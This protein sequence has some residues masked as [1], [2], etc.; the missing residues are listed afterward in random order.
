MS[1]PFKDLDNL[2]S[3]HDHEEKMWSE[4]FA[5]IESKPLWK[6][7]LVVV[8]KALNVAF[9]FTHD[10]VQQT[11]D[12]LTLQFLG[13]RIFNTGACAIKLGLSGYYQ[14]AF[15]LLR[16]VIEVGFLVH[17]FSYWP[18]RIT[19]WKTC[20]EE[21]RKKKFAPVKIRIALDEKEGNKEKKRAKAYETLSQ[22]GS[23]ATYRGFRMTTRQNF[24]EIGPFVDETN[25][26]AFIE[27]LTL[28][29]APTCILYGTMFPN[30]PK[31]IIDFREHVAAELLEAAK[32][33]PSED[34]SKV[35]G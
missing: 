1:E 18:Q 26:R 7:R 27:E 8:E 23:H 24:G 13:I 12:E 11:D 28:R 33:D 19:E 10:Y 15:A 4:S 31:S 9:A 21:E 14:Q 32:K 17:Y 35:P 29:L 22:Y 25:L 30:A 3:T 6:R 5:L 16:D 2:K 34:A 20:S